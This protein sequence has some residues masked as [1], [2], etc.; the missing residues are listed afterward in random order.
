MQTWIRY[1]SEGKPWKTLGGRK[2]HKANVTLP[3]QVY[4]TLPVLVMAHLSSVRQIL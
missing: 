3:S 1:V 4:I 2:I